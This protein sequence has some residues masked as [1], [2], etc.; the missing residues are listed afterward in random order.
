MKK[1]FKRTL[2]SI[3]GIIALLFIITEIFVI[4][5]MLGVGTVTVNI[6]SQLVLIVINISVVLA[7]YFI[8]SKKILKPLTEMDSAAMEL[9]EGNL[10]INVTHKSEDEVGEL[11]DSF[12]NLI[13]GENTMINDMTNIIRQF[14]LGNFNVRTGCREVYKGSFQP[15]LSELTALAIS[16]SD[17]MGNIDEAAIQVSAESNELSECSQ[18]LAQGATDQAA[19]VEQ[20]LSSIISITEQVGENDRATE[21]TCEN[22]RII[23]EHADLSRQKMQDLMGAM[24]KIMETS[25][26]IENIIEEIEDIAAQTN[27]L[28]LNATIEAA[29]AGE[30]GKGF[31]V[32]ADEIRK[33]AENSAACAVTTK[34]LITKSIDDI[35]KG[36]DITSDT[37]QA[38]NEAIQELGKLIEA[39]ESI[40]VNSEKQEISMRE[41]ETGVEQITSTIQNNSAAAQQNSA[42]SQ[43]LAQQ[44]V[45][46]K[47]LVEKFQLRQG[48]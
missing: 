6:I 1:S 17:T 28:S 44:A 20:L 11:A 34:K 3:F 5:E 30:A 23:G 19:V 38:M 9:S 24:N 14:N 21:Q 40:R 15:I 47:E 31:A 4:V 13:V 10:E 16:F 42:S 8:I 18:H 12:R 46:L 22:A 48:A 39:I 43:Q 35:R 41:I 26:Q 2:K 37:A 45:I 7:G 33:L 29:R 25:S 32:V 27:L 36:S